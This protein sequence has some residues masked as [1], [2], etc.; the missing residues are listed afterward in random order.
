MKKDNLKSMKNEKN[1]QKK[2]KIHR[3][4]NIEILYKR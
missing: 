2:R 4:K 1:Y 3:A